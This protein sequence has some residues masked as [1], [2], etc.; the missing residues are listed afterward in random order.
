M[1]HYNLACLGF[2]N[3]GRALAQLLESKRAELQARY[4]L[5]YTLTGLAT[6]RLGWH[7]RPEGY[8]AADLAAGE[9][10]TAVGPWD[11]LSLADWLAQTR[12]DVLFENTSMNPHTGQPALDYA[13]TALKAGVHVVTANKYPVTQTGHPLCHLAGLRS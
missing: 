4:D 9:V 3:V 2:G 10:G 5:T 7:V 8:T 1:P 6:R 12:A 11:A 13:R